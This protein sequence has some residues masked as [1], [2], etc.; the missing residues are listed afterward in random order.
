[1]SGSV[2]TMKLAQYRPDASL[3]TVTVD[4]TD[5]SARDQRTR[6]GPILGRFSFP[7][8]VI[9]QRALAVN[10]TACRLSRLDFMRGSPI[11]GPLR[12]P[13]QLA[14]KLAYAA[15]RSRRDCCN[16]TADTSPSQER[17]G[18][19]FASVINRFDSCA[20]VGYGKPAVRASR[21]ARRP[22]FHTTRAQPN[23]RPSAMR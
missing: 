20:D 11:L 3:I 1:M 6:T 7:S 15:S 10:R 2:S 18:V 12:M 13:L 9:D 17:S 5:G 22:S 16:T 19:R 8:A 23:A 14:K 21:R 4:G